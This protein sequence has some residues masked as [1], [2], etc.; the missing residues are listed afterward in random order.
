MQL[1][2]A[3]KS[4][5]S[6]APTLAPAPGLGSFAAAAPMPDVLSIAP[7]ASPAASPVASPF[8][9][10]A[11]DPAS[12]DNTVSAA[13]PSQS[14]ASE[15]SNSDVASPEASPGAGP[16]IASAIPVG[17]PMPSSAVEI[18]SL[19]LERYLASL[20]PSPAAT[21]ELLPAA[22]PTSGGDTSAAPAVSQAPSAQEV[23]L[24]DNATP[25]P[26][27]APAPSKDVLGSPAVSPDSDMTLTSLV[28]D[29]ALPPLPFLNSPGPT[30][31]TAGGTLLLATTHASML[32]HSSRQH[33]CQACQCIAKSCVHCRCSGPDMSGHVQHICQCHQR[34]NQHPSEPKRLAAS[35]VDRVLPCRHFR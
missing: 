24:E 21:S 20:S 10:L 27:A 19:L 18:Y 34:S 23:S 13:A 14:T 31:P 9:A 17:R 1:Y 2:P 5:I 7:S 33:E 15:P 6:L 16:S 25:S 8:V 32:R 28:P 12:S 11:S 30:A 3:L 35:A 26:A 29:L 22:A 4:G